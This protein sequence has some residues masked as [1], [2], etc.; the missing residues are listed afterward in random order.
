MSSS[1]PNLGLPLLAAAQAQKHVTHNEA[2]AMLDALTQIAVSA[3]ILSPPPGAEVGA[4]FL[5]GEPASG[6]FAAAENCVAALDEGGWRVMA[7]RAGWIAY[8]ESENRLLLFDGA[9]WIDAPA[10][11]ADMFGVNAAADATTRFV[12]ASDACAFTHMGAGVQI[13]LNKAS[14]AQTASVLHQTAWSGRAETGLCG[15]ESYRVKVSQNGTTWRDAAVFD[16]ATGAARF[17]GGVISGAPAGFRNRLRNPSFALNQRGVSGVVTLAAGAY[18]HDGVKAGASGASYQMSA[19]GVDVALTVVSG[20]IIMPIEAGMIEGGAYTLAHEGTAQARVWQGSGVAGTGVYASARRVDGGRVVADVAAGAQTNVEFAPG[21]VLRPQFEPGSVATIFERRPLAVETQ[22]CERY[23]QTS[24][25]ATPAPASFAGAVTRSLDATQ[26][27]PMLPVNY[28]VPM[29]SA[30]TVTLYSP[31][32][33]ASGKIY[34]NS[35]ASDLPAS[36]QNAGRKGFTALVLNTSCATGTQV[37][38]HYSSSAEI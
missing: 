18:G 21:T 30:P 28:R 16:G 24:Y 22:L 31:S 34:L 11:V 12:V 33:G 10:R 4:R 32:S 13:K 17:P 35:P 26:S 6:L 20:S 1:T 23:F 15:D 8:V 37:S 19:S 5:V 25:D 14:A 9:R 29:R 7:P 27:W 38:V 2:L 36:V 3:I